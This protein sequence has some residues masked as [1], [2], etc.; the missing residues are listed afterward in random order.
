MIKNEEDRESII[1]QWKAVRLYQAMVRTNTVGAF[2]GGAVLMP[3]FLNGCNTLVLIFAFAVFERT[4]QILRSENAYPE[5][6]E[7]RTGFKALML[8]SRTSLPWID[9][10]LMSEGRDERHRAAHGLKIVPRA[11]CWRYIDAIERELVSW[12]ALPGPIVAEYVITRGQ[13]Q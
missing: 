9:F 11:E 2:A 3:D 4:L 7:G 12:R 8:A 6:P 1:K 13:A 5:P 10:D